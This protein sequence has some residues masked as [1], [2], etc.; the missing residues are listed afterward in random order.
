MITG[1]Y[2]KLFKYEEL[3]SIDL[4]EKAQAEIM[5]KSTLRFG[6]QTHGL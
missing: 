4:L 3:D 5:I 6:K 2:T 1:S